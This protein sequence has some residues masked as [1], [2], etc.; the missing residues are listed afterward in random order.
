MIKNLVKTVFYLALIAVILSVAVFIIQD[1][2]T[3][4]VVPNAE[5]PVIITIVDK[6]LH[7]PVLGKVIT[8]FVDLL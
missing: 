7:V 4:Y 6:I 2:V 3:Y 8:T 5:T 1:I